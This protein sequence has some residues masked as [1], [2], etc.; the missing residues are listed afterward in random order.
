MFF[1]FYKQEIYDKLSI[2]SLSLAQLFGKAH[3][4]K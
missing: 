1:S 3:Q 4:M 2:V